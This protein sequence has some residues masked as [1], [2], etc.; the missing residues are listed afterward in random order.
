MFF[1]S[2]V[3]NAILDDFCALV[4]Q[5]VRDL[6]RIWCWISEV[7]PVLSPSC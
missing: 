1:F 6:C 4:V 7:N 2:G 5:S 3:T